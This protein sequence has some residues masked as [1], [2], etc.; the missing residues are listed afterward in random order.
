MLYHVYICP[1]NDITHQ[2][3]WADRWGGEV[4][5]EE[6]HR[7]SLQLSPSMTQVNDEVIWV[8]AGAAIWNRVKGTERPEQRQHLL[9]RHVVGG[10]I[11]KIYSSG[12][13]SGTGMIM[14]P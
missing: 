6:E 12:R 14:I 8:T 9:A 1:L 13:S 4:A 2:F 10:E 5:S 3:L 11:I 7:L